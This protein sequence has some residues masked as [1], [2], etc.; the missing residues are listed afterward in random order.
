MKARPFI[1]LTAKMD[2]LISKPVKIH[3][4][5]PQLS[6]SITILYSRLIIVMDMK[7]QWSLLNSGT[8]MIQMFMLKTQDAYY[9]F[10]ILGIP[11]IAGLHHLKDLLEWQTY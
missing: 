5:V 11:R 8:G 2:P 6:S 9:L 10:N 1:I 4:S 3:P 7:I